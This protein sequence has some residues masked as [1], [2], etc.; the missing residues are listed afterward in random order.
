MRKRLAKVLLTVV[1]LAVVVVWV[2]PFFL[3]VVTSLKTQDEVLTDPFGLPSHPTFDAYSTVWS[4][5]NFGLLLRNSALYSVAGSG[6]AL[7]LAAFP[8]YAFSRF[9]IRGG[10]IMFTILL[11]TLMLPQQTVLIPLYSELNALGLL[12][13]QV[14]L[15]LVHAVYGFPYILLLLTGFMV[16]IPRE[17]EAAARVD[18]CAD[19]GVLR[20]LIL[21]LSLPAMAVAFTLNFI[22]IWKE[23]IFALSFLNTDALL[24]I[25]TGILKFTVSQYFTTFT[26]PAAAVVLSLLPILALFVF[27]HRW[28]M[29]GIF[30]GAIK[31]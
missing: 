25:T 21:P 10:K 31:G 24:P 6:L 17:L 14:G 20:H 4:T 18:G 30:V 19:I 9:H 16:S 11:T 26:L 13:T 2:Y 28:I 22:G 12:N 23:F 1:A 8:A 7:A 3:T 15:I 27:A 29:Q 5:L